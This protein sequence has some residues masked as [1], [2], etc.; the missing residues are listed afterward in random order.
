MLL[1]TKEQGAETGCNYTWFAQESSYTKV[2]R[3]SKFPPAE[4]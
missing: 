4:I 3:V 2:F 1:A